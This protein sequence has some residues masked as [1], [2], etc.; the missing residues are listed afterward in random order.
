MSTEQT[1]AQPDCTPTRPGWY[2]FKWQGWRDDGWRIVEV[3]GY[4]GL[5]DPLLTAEIDGAHLPVNRL[6]AEWRGPLLHPDTADGAP[7]RIQEARRKGEPVSRAE[8]LATHVLTAPQPETAKAVPQ[9][10]ELTKERDALA[11]QNRNLQRQITRLCA[12][13]GTTNPNA[14]ALPAETDA[15]FSEGLRRIRQREAATQASADGERPGRADL[16]SSS[17]FGKTLEEDPV[18][19]PQA[20]WLLAEMRKLIKER[21]EARTK[22]GAI[23]IGL[24]YEIGSVSVHDLEE[25]GSLITK[26][27]LPIP[28][29]AADAHMAGAALQDAF[30]AGR[31]LVAVLTLRSEHAAPAEPDV[32]TTPQVARKSDEVDQTPP[33]QITLG[34]PLPVHLP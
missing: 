31:R 16:A 11:M 25:T 5:L 3:R 13:D 28:V 26:E 7:Q 6:R 15:Q 29:D 33:L 27:G 34:T 32:P 19:W 20:Q 2:W 9:V 30:A 17:G 10:A 14:V 1:Q 4:I 22:R 24:P 8:F 12:I 18:L 23:A 21:D